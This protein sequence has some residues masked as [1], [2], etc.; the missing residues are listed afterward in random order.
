MNKQAVSLTQGPIAKGLIAFAFPIFLS[1]LFQ[2][3]YNSIDAAVVGSF[4]GD[5]ALAA[6]G[7]TGSLINLLIGL[8][9]GLATGAGILYAMHYG[10]GDWKGLK[11][12]IDGAMFLAVATGAVISV[13]G[14]AF[15]RQMLI[16]VS[17]PDDVIDL[18][19]SY[20]RIYLAGTIITMVYN[21]GAGLLRAEGDSK[22]PLLYL[23]AGGV[24]NLVLDLLFVAVFNMGVAGAA[25]ATVIAQLVSA[26]L[27]VRRLMMLD[28]R[29]RF[30]PL[31]ITLDK[32]TLWD[33]TRIS[34]P[35]GLQSSMFN[36]ANLLVQA[37]INSF[38]SV[39]M[40]G[41]AAYSKIDGFIYMPTSALSL[42]LSTYVGQNI[43]AGLYSRIAKGIR[44]ALFTALGFVAIMSGC[45]LLFCHQLIGLFTTEPD[46]QA[47]ALQQ[48]RFLA[49]FAWSFVFS[50]IFGGA[51]RGAGDAMKVTVVSALCI[52]VFRVVYLILLLQVFALHDIRIVFSCYPISWCLSSVTM[53]L[54]YFF[55]NG[56]RKTMKKS[57][58]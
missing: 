25:I 7:S 2:Q 12:L 38:G 28:E 31:H 42:A 41:C 6:V 54:L 24:T 5:E 10:A 49:P 43:G 33:L 40:A 52:C 50:D 32:L 55:G 30:H 15:S 18:S 51:I 35:C 4:A 39:T 1:N 20:L 56:M 47:V 8:F 48:M 37:Y 17:T 53:T 22:R 11:K 3:L 36:I 45:V 19:V 13:L 34:V 9:L 58:T 21:V 29:Y 57:A 23:V 46:A 26:V 16:W 44:T 14:Y 27:V